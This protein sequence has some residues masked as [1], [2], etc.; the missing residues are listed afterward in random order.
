MLVYCHSNFML[1]RMVWHTPQT[2]TLLGTTATVREA[3]A[4]WQ[5]LLVMASDHTG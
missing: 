1:H 4:F 3:L 2:D 5:R